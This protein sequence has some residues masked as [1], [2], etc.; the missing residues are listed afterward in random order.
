[1]KD[2]ER[3]NSERYMRYNIR[4][5]NLLIVDLIHIIFINEYI[6]YF[7]VINNMIRVFFFNVLMVL[8]SGY[9][10]VFGGI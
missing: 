4:S 10:L 1:M 7:I 8:E 9:T 6:V 5:I 3:H 2:N